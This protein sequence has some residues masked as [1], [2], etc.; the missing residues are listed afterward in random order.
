[1]KKN[2]SPF[3]LRAHCECQEV[4]RV[5]C[6]VSRTAGEGWNN[7]KS[8]SL[9]HR[10]FQEI[11]SPNLI[12]YSHF[13]FLL[14]FFILT[15]IF[16]L[17]YQEGRPFF[18]FKIKWEFYKLSLKIAPIMQGRKGPRPKVLWKKAHV[19]N[20]QMCV[21]VSLALPSSTNFPIK[22]CASVCRKTR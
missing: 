15:R 14:T 5:R 19:G 4:R 9:F 7:Q 21:Y 10:H 2:L 18:F 6:K 13:L 20:F 3:L 12:F 1:M 8:R 11:I 17:K 16:Y 22:A